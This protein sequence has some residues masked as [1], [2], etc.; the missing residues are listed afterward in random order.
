MG[1]EASGLKL[2]SSTGSWKQQFMV[3]GVKELQDVEEWKHK[4]GFALSKCRRMVQGFAS[5]S[6]KSLFVLKMI[7]YVR[8]GCL[9]PAQVRV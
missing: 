1:D 3:G 5:R 9:Q 6:R 4:S 2:L 8:K 7:K